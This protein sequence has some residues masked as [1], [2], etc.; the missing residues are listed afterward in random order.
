MPERHHVVYLAYDADGQLLYAGMSGSLPVRMRDHRVAHDWWKQVARIELEHFSTRA[1]AL[2][3][4]AQLIG[5]LR[6]PRN[7]MVG[8]GW[9]PWDEEIIRLRRAG[10]TRGEIM[11]ALGIKEKALAKIV[12]RLLATG[13]V[14]R[15][16]GSARYHSSA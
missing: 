12:K 3:R 4:E 8:H 9:S 11:A 16:P 10:K 6:P 7:R 15:V 1:E 5:R 14:S 2:A 13:R